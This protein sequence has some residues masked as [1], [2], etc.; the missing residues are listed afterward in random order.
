[1]FLVWRFFVWKNLISRLT[2]HPDGANQKDAHEEINIYSPEIGRRKKDKYANDLVKIQVC[3]S[4][5]MRA[6]TRR[7]VL[8]KIIE[9]CVD[10]L[11]WCLYKLLKLFT[12]VSIVLQWISI[13]IGKH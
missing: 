5:R 10:T 9:L 8:P 7:E 13:L 6:D 11:S 4:F 12:A 3:A 2:V 1:M